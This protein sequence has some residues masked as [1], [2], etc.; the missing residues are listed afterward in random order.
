MY[1]KQDTMVI[2]WSNR[3]SLIY[4]ASQKKRN[5]ELLR[6]FHNLVTF[7][8]DTSTT[9]CQRNGVKSFVN[10][11]CSYGRYSQWKRIRLI[12]L[13][14]C[15]HYFKQTELCYYYSSFLLTEVSY[16]R[17]ETQLSRN[18][19]FSLKFRYRPPNDFLVSSLQIH[20]NHS[21][22]KYALYEL[23]QMKEEDLSFLKLITFINYNC[24]QVKIK[25]R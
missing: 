25:H 7:V 20:S 23:H 4:S 13:W 10:S 15:K 24:D 9:D 6:F 14:K 12:K 19:I 3:S 21:C 22:V 11:V 18:M 8:I 1:N 16:E 2:T 17:A 5:R